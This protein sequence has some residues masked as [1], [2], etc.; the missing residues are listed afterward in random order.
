MLMIVSSFPLMT[1]PVLA[2]FQETVRGGVPAVTLHS[3][4]T[5]PPT[6]TV[7][8]CICPKAAETRRG[9]RENNFFSNENQKHK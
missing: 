1:L 4:V 9:E 3:F 5:F 8:F 7:T 6:S 2:F